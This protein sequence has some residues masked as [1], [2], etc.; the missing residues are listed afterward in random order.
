[1][2]TPQFEELAVR[3]RDKADFYIVFTREAH[4]KARNAKP[5]GQAATT[6]WKEDENGDHAVTFAEW[7]GPRDMFDPFDLNK[8]DV[9]QAHELLAARKIEQFEAIEEPTTIEERRTLAQRFRDEVPGEIP[10]LIDELDNRT[11]AA[12]GGM[13]NSLFVI[14]PDGTLSHAFEWASMREAD[15]A[16]A[17]VFG[18]SPP[19]VEGH[20]PNWTTIGAQLEKAATA[21]HPVLLQFTAP[22]CTACEVMERETLADP[23]VQTPLA[24]Y[25]RVTLGVEHDDAWA[26]F[27]ALDL[28]ATPAFVIVAPET[29]TVTRKSQGVVAPSKFLEFLAGA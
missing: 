20:P 9:V 22:G 29:R 25:E 15:R 27:E 16:L 4:P 18:Q 10:V 28:S 11:T 6:L 26:L 21:G 23:S 17:E 8:D 7:G 13:P 1:M 5:L 12:Y 19:P 14:K 3:W 2:K 24:G